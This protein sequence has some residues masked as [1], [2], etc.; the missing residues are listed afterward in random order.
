MKDTKPY[1][2]TSR[3]ELKSMRKYEWLYKT[4][5]PRVRTAIRSSLATGKPEKVV[6]HT[7]PRTLKPE[8]PPTPPVQSSSPYDEIELIGYRPTNYTAVP[9]RSA[10]R[11][12]T[13]PAEYGRRDIFQDCHTPIQ[14]THR[15]SGDP[16]L[17]IPIEAK[18]QPKKITRRSV[19][20]KQQSEFNIPIH[21]Y[22]F[23]ESVDP[24]EDIDPW[25]YTR[26]EEIPTS[27]ITIKGMKLNVSRLHQ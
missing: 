12:M 27:G 3:L 25:G 11:G 26:D 8:I 1:W 24:H 19:Q 17:S 15:F 4:N 21:E 22:L 20:S 7:R 13:A 6:I 14:I 10:L 16:I 9:K 23:E 18:K 2:E 5:P